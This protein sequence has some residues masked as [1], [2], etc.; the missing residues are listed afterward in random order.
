VHL[1]ATDAH[2]ADERPPVLSAGRRAAASV[3]GEDAARK[4]VEDNP[5]AIIEGRDLA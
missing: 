5:R 2:W 1:L 4:L 3:V